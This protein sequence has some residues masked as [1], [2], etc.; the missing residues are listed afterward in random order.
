MHRSAKLGPAK[1]RT[2]AALLP[3]SKRYDSVQ[4]SLDTG[5]SITKARA[6][7]ARCAVLKR[8][9]ESFARLTVAQLY[10]LLVEAEVPRPRVDGG[11]CGVGAEGRAAASGEPRRVVYG[12]DDEPEFVAPLLLVDV[13]DRADFEDCHIMT[14]MCCSALDIRQERIPREI[15]QLRGRPTAKLVLYDEG[16]EAAPDVA[17]RFTTRGFTNV[18]VLSGGLRAVA[19]RSP[20]LIDGPV[21]DWLVEAVSPSKPGTAASARSGAPH[22]AASTARPG[23]GGRAAA[24]PPSRAARS[25]A[26][27]APAPARPPLPAGMFTP[28]A[29]PVATA[30]EARHATA[31]R[32]LSGRSGSAAAA[33]IGMP[34]HGPSPGRR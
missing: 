8:M 15:A 3:K 9:D 5:A 12:A 24:G 1:A 2:P 26:A 11:A 25:S 14:A 22:S 19:R 18:F 23:R 17:H 33:L 31:M 16:E 4:S 32:G 6:K 10:E 7:P 21:P 29:D 20:L 28:D 13:R 34:T 30:A 27:A